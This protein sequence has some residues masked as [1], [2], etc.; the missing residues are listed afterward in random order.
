M[1]ILFY[2]PFS[3]PNG[4]GAT[5]RM[6]AYGQGL[7]LLGCNFNLFCVE[8]TEIEPSVQNREIFGET[9]RIKFRYTCGTTV[10]SKSLL[11][12]KVD[13]LKGVLGLFWGIIEEHRQKQIDVVIYYTAKSTIHTLAGWFACKL[14]NITFYA[15]T[16]EFPFVYEQKSFVKNIKILI[17]QTFTC[18][19]YDGIIIISTLLEKHYAKLLRKSAKII[20]IPIIVDTYM[21]RP[22][23]TNNEIVTICYCGHLCNL[24]ELENLL[25]VFSKIVS[26]YENI[27]LKIVGDIDK[28]PHKDKVFS[29][30]L[31]DKLKNKI[32]FT[33]LVAHSNLSDEF[34]SVDIFVLPRP[35]G[36]F[37]SAGFPT[38][39]GEY[40]ASGKPVITTK[41]GDIPLYLTHKVDAYLVEPDDNETFAKTLCYVLNN[42]DKARIVGMNGRQT[43]LK[44]FSSDVNSY[45]LLEHLRTK[46]NR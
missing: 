34:A 27:A 42:P 16:T 46:L 15:E 24:Q 1:N 26:K 22:T 5:T 33:G 39:L 44:Y 31:G 19:F 18:K 10:S 9:N 23:I 4:T 17:Y 45:L 41:T 25:I 43:C 38:K 3:Y 6:R 14:C 40:L 36:L 32:N 21:F 7:T 37:S 29:I 8:P 2:G 28:S 35:S 13:L 11:R 30:A 12:R 20:R